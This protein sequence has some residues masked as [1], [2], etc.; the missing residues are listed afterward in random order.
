MKKVYIYGAGKYGKILYEKLHTQTDISIQG[1]IDSYKKELKRYLGLPVKIPHQIQDTSAR[2]IIAAQNINS[3]KEMARELIEK[4]ITDIWFF[5]NNGQETTDFW[6]GNFIKIDMQWD[7][8][9]NHVEMHIIDACNLN[10]RGC[11]HFAPLFLKDIPDYSSRI[12]DVKTIASKIDYIHNFYIMG[13]E[14]LLN[15][16]LDRYVVDIRKLLPN[17]RLYVVTNGLLVPKMNPE[18][19]YAIKQNRVILSI[20]EYLPTKKIK[21]SINDVLN[22]Y[23]IWYEYR[24][25]D[26]KKMFGIPLS[27][28]RKSKH[29]HKCLSDGCINI[30]NGMISRC[31][32]V[33]YIHKLNEAFGTNLPQDGVYSLKDLSGKEIEDLV[34]MKIPLCNH[35]VDYRIPWGKCGRKVTVEDFTVTD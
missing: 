19:L 27:L 6:Q 10:C 21:T 12:E 8:V 29:A 1:F 32:T 20:S 11:T 24:P 26:E 14:P 15:P 22:E 7:T 25:Y 23:N 13:G 35:C 5:D 17:T 4:G 16:E 18:L 3:V 9:L 34:K 28:S 33:M 30:W 2:Y 31:P